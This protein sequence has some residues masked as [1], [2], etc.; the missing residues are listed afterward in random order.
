MGAP[1]P[2]KVAATPA[3]APEGA[4]PISL[5]GLP[6]PTSSALTEVPASFADL[7]AVRTYLNTLVTELKASPYF[8]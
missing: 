8:S 4:I 3:Q 1:I 5:S 6:A 2:Y 7:A